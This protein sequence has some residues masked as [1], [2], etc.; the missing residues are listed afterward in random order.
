[1][2]VFLA[3]AAG[4]IGRRLLPLLIGAGHQVTGTTRLAETGKELARADL[5]FDPEFRSAVPAQARK[6][7][8]G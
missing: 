5:G 8:E 2:R 7:P 1:M 4:A 6:A 3:G